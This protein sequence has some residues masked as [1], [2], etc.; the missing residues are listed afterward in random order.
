MTKKRKIKSTLSG[1]PKPQFVRWVVAVLGIIVAIGLGGVAEGQVVYPTGGPAQDVH[2]VQAAVNSGGTVLLKATDRTG[3]PQ[4]FNFGTAGGAAG[5]YVEIN[6]DVVIV[7]E[8]GSITLPD[9]RTA[10]RTTIYGGGAGTQSDEDA[11]PD[12]RGAF[13]VMNGSFEISG[14]WLDNSYWSS[15]FVRGCT[16]ARISDNVMTYIRPVKSIVSGEEWRSWAKPIVFAEW[17]SSDIFGDIII[18]GN[19]IEFNPNPPFVVRWPE[20]ISVIRIQS[21]PMP[22]ISI[23]GNTVEHPGIDAGRDTKGIQCWHPATIK[24]NTIRGWMYDGIMSQSI[25]DWVAGVFSSSVIEGNTIRGEMWRGIDVAWCNGTLVKNN[26]ISG[27]CIYSVRLYKS[28][29]TVVSSN[30][31]SGTGRVGIRLWSDGATI[32]R[33]TI[34]HFR[35]TIRWGAPIIVWR[36]SDC[37]VTDNELIDVYDPDNYAQGNGPVAGIRISGVGICDN[38]SLLDNDYR[39]SG[40]PGLTAQSDGPFC[41]LLEE[42]TKNNFVKEQGGYP[43]GTDAKTQV[44]DGGYLYQDDYVN[45]VW[46]TTNRVVGH[47]A[48]QMAQQEDLNPGIGQ[49]LK[50]IRDAS[51]ESEEE[52]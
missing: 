7:G 16:G 14:L 3:A 9:G 33:N 8:P 18:E 44:F 26:T 1:E 52:E 20:G 49:R 28:P 24:D 4:Y 51:G 36:S 2:N 35:C 39:Q 31:I 29:N 6:N 11:N 27:S 13:T 48:S 40:L 10:D 5:K 46:T 30:T 42:G 45:W 21:S 17:P 47:D 32:I 19:Y 23:I 22:N 15:V 41:V 37:T 12:L 38:N 43:Q 34:K 50:A 25:V